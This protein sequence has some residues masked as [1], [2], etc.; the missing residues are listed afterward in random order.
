MCKKKDVVYLLD[1]KIIHFKR[2]KGL[3]NP[4]DEKGE[5]S[6]DSGR[7]WLLPM[8][9]KFLLIEGQKAEKKFLYPLSP[10]TKNDN[11]KTKFKGVILF[12]ITPF[13]LY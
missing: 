12:W 8:A 5:I 6:M 13:F 9:E 4:L 2:W 3:S 7:E 10:V 1:F 11:K